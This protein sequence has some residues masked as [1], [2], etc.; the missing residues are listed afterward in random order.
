M[1]PQGRPHVNHYGISQILCGSLALVKN[2]KSANIVNLAMG[3]RGYA[4]YLAKMLH[5][6]AT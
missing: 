5:D 1:S 6:Y 4:R 3:G 2:E